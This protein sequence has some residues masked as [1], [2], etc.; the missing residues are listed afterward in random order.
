MRIARTM[1]GI[2]ACVCALV[3]TSWARG[4][5]ANAAVAEKAAQID[6]SLQKVVTAYRAKKVEEMKSLVG[7][8]ETMIGEL[9]AEGVDVEPLRTRLA[10]A[11]RLLKRQQEEAVASATASTAASPMPRPNPTPAPRPATPRPT[12]GASGRVSF[13]GEVAPLLVE[14]CA[15]CHIRNQ[16]GNF[17]MASFND[18]MRGT[19]DGGPVFRPGRGEGSRLIDLLESGSMPPNGNALSSDQV[20]TVTRWINE[21]ANFDGP[22]PNA[23]LVGLVPGTDGAGMLTAT[24]ATGRESVQFVR[25]L[26]PVLVENCVQCHSGARPS[27]NLSLATF[28]GILA[29]GRSGRVITPGNPGNSLLI[30]KLKGTARIGEQM[31]LRM[32]PLPAEVIAMFETWIA[33]GARFDDPNPDRALAMI[34]G[35]REA[36]RMS[37]DELAAKR[38]D[39]AML[40]WKTSNTEV[41]PDRL[42]T[43]DFVILGNI[44]PSRIEELSRQAEAMKA[45]VA[46]AFKVPLDQPLLK[47][48]L[49]IFAFDR[50]FDYTEFS[51]MVEKREVPREMSGHWFFNY[52]DA[53]AAIY[54]PKDDPSGKLLGGLLAETLSGAYLESLGEMPQWFVTGA[55]RA[56]A[57]RLEPS[58]PA[59]KQWQ[60]SVPPAL[61]AGGQLDAFLDSRSLDSNGL[62]LS[63]GFGKWLTTGNNGSRYQALLS[64]MKRGSSFNQ[65]FQAAYQNNP[66]TLFAQWARG[67]SR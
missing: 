53:Y 39:R 34:V 17:S 14:R 36:R 55:A 18:L 10:A 1:M 4:A 37:H 38:A 23:P 7:D 44:G 49:T 15:G 66:K 65:A 43:S 47:G 25:D 2:V 19:P 3:W 56:H 30:Q 22:N 67:A 5:E 48:R 6:D 24:R 40:N 21:G 61:A 29:G 20:A 42:D 54:V 9:A 57:E 50:R 27:E 63:Y 13:V 26:A 60:D 62:A 51:L 11:Q 41:V 59:L 35:M 16:R 12:P 46:G 64:Q 52:I 28:N 33:E 8:I 31:P 32:G 58:N 45:K